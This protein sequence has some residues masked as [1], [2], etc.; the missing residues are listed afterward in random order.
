MTA[1]TSNRPRWLQFSLRTLLVIMAVVASYFAGWASHREWNK[2]TIDE[3]IL[4]ATQRVGA[5]GQVQVET[6]KVVPGGFILRGKKEDVAEME[7]A[8]RDIAAAARK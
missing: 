7:K 3:A 8:V 1:L 2:R 5:A 4:K 6:S